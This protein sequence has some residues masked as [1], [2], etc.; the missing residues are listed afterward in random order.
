M[1]TKKTRK[2]SWLYHI[3]FE[4]KLGWLFAFMVVSYLAMG[5]MSYALKGNFRYFSGATLQTMAGQ[6]PEI[7]ILAIGCMLPMITGGIDL[8]MIGKANLSGIV[9]AAF[10]KALI[11]DTTPEGTQALISIAA[12]LL[13]V[14]VGALAGL[15]NG[16]I[17]SKFNT[18]PLIVTL[19]S[20]YVYMGIAV[21]ITE[22]QSIVGLP[23]AFNSIG[24]GM[25]F[26]AIPIQFVILV[27]VALIIWFLITRTA[28]GTKLYM[29]GSN[30]VAAEF[31]GIN[32]TRLLCATYTISGVLSAL[33]GCILFGRSSQANAD[34]GTTYTL[35]AIMIAVLGGTNPNGGEGN[36]LGV[37]F[38][39][40]TMQFLATGMNFF[41][42]TNVTYLKDIVWGAVL[43]IVMVV[44]YISASGNEKRRLRQ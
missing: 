8:S 44:N 7:G 42:V 28:Y 10:M 41:Q 13:A 25:L 5:F 16:L 12:I 32:M 17:I 15:L 2:T 26:G 19:G 22:G 30:M 1:E 20:N 39:M 21:V 9:A 23:K 40:F 33:S 6:I 34:Y 14:V 3:F 29:T 24:Q 11:S 43:I 18:P 4:T 27:L 36:V 37:V 38:A 35:Q 31:S